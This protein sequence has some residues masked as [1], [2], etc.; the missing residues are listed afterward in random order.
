[1]SFSIYNATTANKTRL[2]TPRDYSPFSGICTVCT[3]NCQG[4]CEIG[5]SA[6]RG[7]EL[8]YPTERATSQT[9]SEKDYPIDFSHFNVNGRCFGAFGSKS[10]S[11]AFPDIDL[12]I[13]AGNKKDRLILKSPFVFPAIAKLNW[14]GYFSGAA[15]SGLIATIG[16][17]MPTTDPDCVIKNGRITDLPMLKE[18]VSF[19]L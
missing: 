12:S 8:L 2:R 3:N 9:A 10:N 7:S 19:L 13:E 11:T 1:M 14:K 17:D 15:V 6:I 4:P 5:R 16:E 18:N